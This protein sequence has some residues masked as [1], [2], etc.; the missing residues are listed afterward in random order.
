MDWHEVFQK[1][2]KNIEPEYDIRHL[3]V[4]NQGSD[5]AVLCLGDSWTYGDSLPDDQRLSQIYGRLI[6]NHLKADLIN[7]GCRG[8]SN[9]WILAVGEMLLENVL[10]QSYQ[11]IYVVITLTENGRDIGSAACFQFDYIEHFKL[12]PS[13]EKYEDLLRQIE[14]HWLQQLRSM[15]S[16]H[17]S[18]KFF[19]GQNFV[20]HPIYE[21]IR[22]LGVH[23][24]DS[25]WIEILADN[26][27]IHRPDRTN[28]VT[29]WIFDIVMKCNHIAMINDISIFKS[30][31]IPYID[32]ANRVNSWLD[33]SDLNFKIA[34]KHPTAKGHQ[35]WA[36]HII[37]KMGL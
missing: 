25:N 30:W 20:W 8:Y 2:L 17:N 10:N 12:G 33:R 11:D 5:R 29:G 28:L 26:Q 27:G 37:E 36:D 35:L 16:K 32:A 1:S 23:T 34:S 18:K 24:T 21:K 7:L 3:S 22:D 6:A 13:H 31:I 14:K 9:S 15:I 4:C 19:V